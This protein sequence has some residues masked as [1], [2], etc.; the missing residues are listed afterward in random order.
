MHHVSALKTH[1]VYNSHHHYYHYH[2]DVLTAQIHWTLSFPTSL[3]VCPFVEV[4][5]IT[6]LMSS[7]YIFNHAQYVLFF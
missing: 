7:P 3:L 4:D 1:E 6:S 5:L 2:Q